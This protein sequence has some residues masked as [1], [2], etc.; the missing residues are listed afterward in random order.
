MAED[1]DEDQEEFIVR[2]AKSGHEFEERRRTVKLAMRLAVS[3][4]EQENVFPEGIFALDG[5]QVVSA[6]RIADVFEEEWHEQH[7]KPM[8]SSQD[9]R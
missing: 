2:Y 8:R 5:T 1:H 3:L 6:A 4:Y 9:L 7:D